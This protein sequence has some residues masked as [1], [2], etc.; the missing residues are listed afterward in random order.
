MKKLTLFII[1]FMV[2]GLVGC[3]NEPKKPAGPNTYNITWNNWDGT[4]LGTDTVEEGETPVYNYATPTR[5]QDA[6]YTYSFIGW[7]P[8]VVPADS[9]ATYVA[10]YSSTIREYLISWM[11]EGE[12]AYNDMVAYGTVPTYGGQTPAKPSTAQ[13]DYVFSG[14]DH[15]PVAVTGTDT[16]VAVFESV[17]RSYNITFY[18]EDGA[19]VLDTVSAD[20]GTVPTATVTPSKEDDTTNHL[21]YE[22]GGWSTEVVAVTG[23][24]SYVATY[25]SSP[26][27][28]LLT[29]NDH[30]VVKG[31]LDSNYTGEIVIPSTWRGL[32]VTEV[33]A[34]SFNSKRGITKVTIGEGVE[35][36]RDFAFQNCDDLSRIVFPNTHIEVGYYGFSYLDSLEFLKLGNDMQLDTGAFCGCNN[37]VQIETGT[38]L[39]NMVGYYHFYDCYSMTELVNNTSAD[40]ISS[41]GG[42]EQ[43]WIGVVKPE[44]KGAFGKYISEYSNEATIITYKPKGSN[45]IYAVAVSKDSNMDTLKTPNNVT[46][47]KDGFA[48][49]SEN[50]KHVYINENITDLGRY[51]F[52]EN[53]YL[54]DV[55][56]YGTSPLEI[57]Y[58]CFEDCR[59]LT[60]VDFGSRTITGI[61]SEAFAGCRSLASFTIPSTMTKLNESFYDCGFTT[62]HIPSTI[63]TIYAN[64]AS[65][66]ANLTSFTVDSNSD[67]FTAING[68][69]YSKDGTKLIAYA[70]GKD[71]TTFTVPEGTT[72]LG[73]YSLTSTTKVQTIKLPSTLVHFEYN[74]IGAGEA[75]TSI[76]Y[77]GTMAELQNISG[78][79]SLWN[80]PPITCSDGVI[81]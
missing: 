25:N 14:W 32:P 16:Y 9:D 45:D 48:H 76:T 70:N 36:I 5:E 21:T 43:S 46:K 37:L 62:L 73:K 38:N 4:I 8:E 55:T 63:T 2:A 59:S 53:Y 30:Y 78:F 69:L 47:F 26:L 15:E 49:S 35:V 80:L 34:H 72:T 51:P 58:R 41:F 20:Y 66:C 13:Y 54:E 12:V 6:Q 44:D 60:T 39:P 7:E 81:E 74:S 50:L 31:L 68:D 19:T 3:K 65:H 67:Y 1:P 28:F 17:L 57:P 22:F 75:L 61:G 27:K 42:A 29:D 56:F 79:S 10:Q 23:E 71:S 33:A 24:A 40:T 18:D 52:S 64:P 77:P 11:V